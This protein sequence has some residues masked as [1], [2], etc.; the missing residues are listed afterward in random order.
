MTITEIQNRTPAVERIRW[1]TIEARAFSLGWEEHSVRLAAA[2]IAAFAATKTG[3][4]KTRLN[5]IAAFMSNHRDWC[6]QD[7][8][9]YAD[10]VAGFNADEAFRRGVVL[11]M[12]PRTRKK[13]R[14]AWE[15][16]Y[17]GLG[18]AAW[19]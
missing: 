11:G 3:R 15:A 5:A 19:Q 8:V 4:V 10:L 9:D 12:P 18:D 6:Y 2:R 14:A 13:L 1:A 16:R 17:P 7:F